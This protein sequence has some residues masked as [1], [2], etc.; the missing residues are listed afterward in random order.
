MYNLFDRARGVLK[1]LSELLV[2]VHSRRK[3]VAGFGQG[4]AKREQPLAL[5]YQYPTHFW[6][7][8]S[9]NIYVGITHNY[10]MKVQRNFRPTERRVHRSD[11]DE[12]GR[13][14]ISQTSSVI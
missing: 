10:Y 11:Y 14:V 9:F 2:I 13:F 5:I 1:Y 7:Y 8:T 6:I 3:T 4:Y 12:L